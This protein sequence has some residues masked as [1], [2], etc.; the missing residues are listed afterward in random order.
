MKGL[1]HVPNPEK[2]MREER[3]KVC[4]PVINRGKLWYD[5][6]TPLQLG[7]L[8]SWYQA[9]LDAPKTLKYPVAPAWLN[10]SLSEEEIII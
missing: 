3:E 2:L 4:F 6:L 9:W 1:Y 10:N 8:K 5:R 7:E